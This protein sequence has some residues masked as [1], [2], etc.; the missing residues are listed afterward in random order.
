MAM[1]RGFPCFSLRKRRESAYSKGVLADIM[2]LRVGGYS[3]EGAYS[4]KYDVS[5]RV[6][7][8]VSGASGHSSPS[9]CEQPVQSSS[10]L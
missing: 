2:V 1:E 10:G 3:V 7:L 8:S 4:R 9:N 6:D 5:C